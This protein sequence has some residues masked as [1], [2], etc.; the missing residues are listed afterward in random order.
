MA[1]LKIPKP[2]K[3]ILNGSNP[4]EDWPFVVPDKLRG[5]YA[6]AVAQWNLVGRWSRSAQR[7][8]YCPIQMMALLSWLTC[9][10]GRVCPLTLLPQIIATSPYHVPD[11]RIM[12]F[13]G[14]WLREVDCG[15]R[16]VDMGCSV[17]KN[18]WRDGHE[19][20]DFI[21]RKDGVEKTVSIK[22]EGRASSA[23]WTARKSAKCK[24]DVVLLAENSGIGLH[25]VSDASLARLF[26]NSES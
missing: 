13:H 1:T 6:N 19:G 25:V 18:P 23:Y 11:D 16:L 26:A 10:V 17:F 2:L 8:T 21:V 3:A 12:Q 22:H 5:S 9:H 4:Y 14:A 7:N 24:A 15:I 20:I